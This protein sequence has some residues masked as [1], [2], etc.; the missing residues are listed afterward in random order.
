MS[1]NAWEY[2]EILDDIE[3]DKEIVERDQ[4]MVEVG[5]K[6]LEREEC[7]FRQTQKYWER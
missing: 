2:W 5:Q 1:K 7:A 3:R 4:E 6:L